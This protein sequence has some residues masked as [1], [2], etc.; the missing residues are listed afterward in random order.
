MDLITNVATNAFKVDKVNEFHRLMNEIVTPG[1]L[2]VETLKDNYFRLSC[3]DE[4][5]GRLVNAKADYDAWLKGLQ[6]VLAEGSD[7]ILYQVW[8]CEEA[9]IVNGSA[10][11]ITSEAIKTIDLTTV[12]EL[13][14][15]EL[16]EAATS[17]P[18]RAEREAKEM[19]E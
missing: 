1:E 13:Q 10:T 18:T 8:H 14:A 11:V 19:L 3:D 17:C 2:K 12:A 16:L 9:P 15:R 5:R 4:I 6:E 7:V